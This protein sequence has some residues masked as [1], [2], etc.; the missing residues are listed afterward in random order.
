MFPDFSQL[1]K[2][3]LKELRCFFVCSQHKKRKKKERKEKRGTPAGYDGMQWNPST[4][5]A[6]VVCF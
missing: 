4:Q 3:R 2:R 5:E 6:G 1:K